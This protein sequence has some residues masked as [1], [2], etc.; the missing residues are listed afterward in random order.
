MLLGIQASFLVLCFLWNDP[1]KPI[2]KYYGTDLHL[3]IVT[4]NIA[5][6]HRN[7]N[8]PS[9]LL[10]CKEI[11]T[12]ILTAL[13]LDLTIL[14]LF[15]NV[16]W[17][18]ILKNY[19]WKLIEVEQLARSLAKLRFYFVS[20]MVSAWGDIMQ[21]CLQWHF[22][23]AVLPVL[24]SAEGRKLNLVMNHLNYCLSCLQQYQP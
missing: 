11:D 21:M 18:K 9:F 20:F 17:C 14:Q 16:N 6:M 23:C 13:W 4:G 2:R 3:I 22:P 24:A 7:L 19:V 8:I 12:L 10:L 5:L 15:F 1:R